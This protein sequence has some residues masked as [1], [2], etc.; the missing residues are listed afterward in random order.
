[1]RALTKTREALYSEVIRIISIK[2]ASEGEEKQICPTP[3]S[4]E[5]ALSLILSLVPGMGW[6]IGERGGVA[7]SLL[8]VPP[9]IKA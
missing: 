4:R 2:W 6:R 5:P 1:M 7:C 8:S 3:S 9:P